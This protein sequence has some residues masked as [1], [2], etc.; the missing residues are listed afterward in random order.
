MYC[1][2]WMRGMQGHGYQIQSGH[3]FDVIGRWVLNG[4]TEASS[5]MESFTKERNWKAIVLLRQEF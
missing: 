5:G 1:V 4:E 3:S 2:M